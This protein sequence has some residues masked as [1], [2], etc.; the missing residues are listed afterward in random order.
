MPV[1]YEYGVVKATI[2]GCLAK[3][4]MCFITF[5]ISK[6][7]LKMKGITYD[8]MVMCPFDKVS[9]R[10]GEGGRTPKKYVI[11]FKAK[12]FAES[13]CSMMV[14]SD[15]WQAQIIHE[16]SGKPVICSHTDELFY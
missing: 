14:E 13:G 1:I 10:V 16:H 8:K 7:W 15:P 11:E 9:K 4:Q 3:K 5:Q 2:F 6:E 12:P